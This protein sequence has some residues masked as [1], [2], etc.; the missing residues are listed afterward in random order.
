MFNPCKLYRFIQY[1]YDITFLTLFSHWTLQTLETPRLLRLLRLRHPHAVTSFAV[2]ALTMW[3]LLFDSQVT[4]QQ[5][6]QL[7]M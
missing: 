7:P 2:K 1:A 5:D 4:S 3:K 6:Q